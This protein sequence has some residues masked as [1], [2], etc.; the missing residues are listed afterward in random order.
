[1]SVRRRVV[2]RQHLA[3]AAAE[4]HALEQCEEAPSSLQLTTIG[5]SSRQYGFCT[6]VA[7]KGVY[8][9]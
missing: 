3:A 5:V 2:R 6:M 8:S 4:F 7:T 1:M 9:T